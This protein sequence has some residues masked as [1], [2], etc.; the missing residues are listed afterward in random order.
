MKEKSNPNYCFVNNFL[1]QL[2]ALLIL[3][4][5]MAPSY[6]GCDIYSN[7]NEF[8]AQYTVMANFQ[9]ISINPAEP[10]G[11]VMQKQEI[12]R[13]T[14]PTPMYDGCQFGFSGSGYPYEYIVGTGQPAPGGACQTG[15]P[16]IGVRVS[17]NDP[18]H[19]NLAL[20]N[21]GSFSSAIGDIGFMGVGSC[22]ELQPYG[23]VQVSHWVRIAGQPR[24]PTWTI[25]IVKTADNPQL[26]T[27]YLGSLF[28]LT[29][30]GTGLVS[31]GNGTP[32]VAVTKTVAAC[33]VANNGVI[34]V[35]MG[36]INA[37]KIR[38]G[39]VTDVAFQIP[40]NCAVG[41]NVQLSLDSTTILSN[42]PGVIGVSGGEWGG[43]GCGHWCVV[44]R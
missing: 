23:M 2:S 39:D 11:T 18:P 13:Y 21:G 24:N 16:G 42:F 5:G 10:I 37:N 44:Q 31:I 41:A 7:P 32:A 6:A 27:G 8:F 40:M 14:G 1:A 26:G 19:F 38:S 30:F 9:N 12:S 28:R 22:R 25:S 35:A 34:P 33:T 4:L 17:V 15:I 36:V 29:S 43:S 3:F 20:S